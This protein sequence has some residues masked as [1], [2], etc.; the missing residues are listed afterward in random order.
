MFRTGKAEHPSTTPGPT[1]RG[2]RGRLWECL[3]CGGL[4][5]SALAS[6]AMPVLGGPLWTALRLHSS[7]PRPHTPYAAC[8][9]SSWWEARRAHGQASCWWG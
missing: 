6:Q 1:A 2:A 5:K 4:G 8:W 9:R 7:V 3:A